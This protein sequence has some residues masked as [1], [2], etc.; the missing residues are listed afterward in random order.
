VP[1]VFLR[2]LLLIVLV[3]ATIALFFH[4]P[5]ANNFKTSQWEDIMFFSHDQKTTFADAFRSGSYWRGLYRPLSTNVY[6]HVAR[7]LGEDPLIDHLGICHTVSVALFAIN[8][9]LAFWVC[10]SF[11]SYSAALIVALLFASRLSNTETMLYTSQMQTLLPVTFSLLAIKAY[12]AALERDYHPGLLVSSTAFVFLGLLCK[13]TVVTIPPLCLLFA[14]ALAPSSSRRGAVQVALA[15]LPL[16]GLLAWYLLANNFL[17][18][19]NNPYWQYQWSPPEITGNFVGYLVSYSN[20]AVRPV[21]LAGQAVFLNAYPVIMQAQQSLVL[22]IGFWIAIALGATAILLAQWGRGAWRPSQDLLWT[23]LGFAIF[24]AA[25]APVVI[26]KDRL[27][28]YYGYFGNFGLSVVLVGAAQVLVR[29]LLAFRSCRLE[30]AATTP[31]G[32]A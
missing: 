28:M 9:L 23:A 3:G 14:F 30:A 4:Q 22:R 19:Q 5:I 1:R 15:A 11:W 6:Y 32:T 24:V 17:L 7:M 18:I 20:L 8:V 27:L 31:I 16:V 29:R 12:L 25:L 13:E 26:F 2:V 10:R 21:Q